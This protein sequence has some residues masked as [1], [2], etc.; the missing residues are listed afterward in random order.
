MAGLVVVVG[1]EEHLVEETSLVA[2]HSQEATLSHHLPDRCLL[3][4]AMA[5]EEEALVVTVV[6]SEAV[7]EGQGAVVVEVV[8]DLVGV[9]VA[10]PDRVVVLESGT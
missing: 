6:D 9:V 7:A 2:I 10:S 3:P 4:K 8:V 5:L 1:L